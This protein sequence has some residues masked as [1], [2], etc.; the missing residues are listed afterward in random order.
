LF[1]RLKS[2]KELYDSTERMKQKNDK[3]M[4][5]LNQRLKD[6]TKDSLLNQ[7]LKD[8]KQQQ[9]QDLTKVSLDVGKRKYLRK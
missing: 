1:S 3:F 4:E 7:R 2:Y 5:D 9:Q 6:L 8:L